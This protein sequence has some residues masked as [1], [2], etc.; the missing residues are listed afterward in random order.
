MDAIQ[1]QYNLIEC[2]LGST[3]CKNKTKKYDSGPNRTIGLLITYI[4]KQRVIALHYFC[5][6]MLLDKNRISQHPLF[7]NNWLRGKKKENCT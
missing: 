1:K 5:S 6:S 2:D 7:V 3:M 4:T